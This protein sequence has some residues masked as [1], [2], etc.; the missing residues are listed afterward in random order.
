MKRT[1]ASVAAVAA[2]LVAF[3]APAAAASADPEDVVVLS[4]TAY[5]AEGQTVG[6]VVLF[7]GEAVI[8]GTV[9]GSVVAFDGRVTIAGSV[10]DDV[11]AFNGLLQVRSGGSVGG[12]VFADT[13]VIAPGA[14]IGGQANDIADLGWLTGGGFAFVAGLAVWLAVTISV[15]LL[16][17]IV[18]WLAPRA[19]DATV[20][21][22]RSGAG[23]AIGW[24]LA[25]F[26]GL[27]VL[28]IAAVATLVG[29]PFGVGLMLALA[30]IYAMG[31]TASTWILGRALVREP[32]SRFGAFL[33]G[34]AIL[35]AVSAVPVLGGIVWFLATVFG[36]GAIVVATW[37][38]REAGVAAPA[39]R[40]VLPPAPPAG[41]PA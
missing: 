1:L 17:L 25:L 4:G 9:E 40:V 26:L 23:P 38:S 35:A 11:I 14:T 37:R 24:G 15:L 2:L 34:W 39:P 27:P 3:A 7:H 32:R 6:S 20:R 12:D 5:V 41:A 21:A 10:E 33:A 22:S 28:A 36:L 8:E 19:V 16:G 18:L 13:R 30:L 29:I 31:Y